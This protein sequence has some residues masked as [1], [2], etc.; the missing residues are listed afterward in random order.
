MTVELCKAL[1]MLQPY[2]QGNRE[3]H[4]LL[5]GV[6]L[7]NTRVVGQEGTHLQATVGN[8][9]A[10][11][12][13]MAHLLP[14]L[15]QHVDIACKLSLDTWNGRIAPQVVIEDMRVSCRA[16]TRQTHA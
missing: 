3:P 13:R 15:A 16:E 12:F 14:Q 6:Q 8:C 9:K 7:S 2:G 5:S 11:A 4:F 10:I 1:E